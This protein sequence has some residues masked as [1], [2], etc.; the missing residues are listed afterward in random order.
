MVATLFSVISENKENRKKSFEIF[1]KEKL[2]GQQVVPDLVL[3]LSYQSY[4][5]V[6]Q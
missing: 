2:F 4:S 6:V 5:K 3:L 1:G